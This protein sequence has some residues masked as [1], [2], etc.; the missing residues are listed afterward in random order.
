MAHE[1]RMTHRV[2]FAETDM[3]GIVHFANFFRYMENTEHEFF[4]S[5]GLSIHMQDE[6]R[7]VGWPRVH[8]EC[9][10]QQPLRFE[11]LVEVQLL[12]REKKSKSLRYEF[13]FRKLTD[14]GAVE[15]ARGRITAVCVSLD[16]EAG[17]MRA[18][19]IPPQIADRIEAAP[20][21]GEPDA[22]GGTEA[23]SGSAKELGA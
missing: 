13:V 10:Y 12:V 3:A 9:D 23:R 16:R 8:A 5:L 1:F 20:P 2:E 22:A 7:T 11:D 15:I 6:G 18:V 21:S 14:A 17:R 4:R 19:Q